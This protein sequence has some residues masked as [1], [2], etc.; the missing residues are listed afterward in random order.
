MGKLRSVTT[1]IGCLFFTLV[2]NLQLSAQEKTIVEIMAKEEMFL[3]DIVAKN[4]SSDGKKIFLLGMV[5]SGFFKLT[6][7]DLY[8]GKISQVNI[9]FKT[10][11]EDISLFCSTLDNQ[12]LIIGAPMF[13]L[14]PLGQFPLAYWGDTIYVYDLQKFTK[15]RVKVKSEL[16]NLS[17]LSEAV[18]L[19]NKKIL[20]RQHGTIILF[21]LLTGKEVWHFDI[22]H[23]YHDSHVDFMSFSPD[24]KYLITDNQL[25]DID[26]AEV[27]FVLPKKEYFVGFSPDNKYAIIMKK[28]EQGEG[29]QNEGNKTKATL[30]FL[31]VLTLKIDKHFDNIEST[32]GPIIHSCDKRNIFY[33]TKKSD[34]TW[35]KLDITTGDY[36]TFE[37][38]TK[39]SHERPSVISGN[40]RYVIFTAGFTTGRGLGSRFS[41]FD[42]TNGEVILTIIFYSFR[43]DGWVAFTNTGYY[44]SSSYSIED[45]FLKVAEGGKVYNITLYRD[46]LRKPTVIKSILADVYSHILN[47]P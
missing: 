33:K 8:S 3:S 36:M 34:N 7:I 42:I 12:Y 30:S 6:I 29:Q 10:M 25:W 44:D 21:D 20:L 35:A 45:K 37:I 17:D 23:D 27:K 1:T 4:V 13:Y 24:G 2:L 39:D 47:P 28:D 5:E 14:S 40:R 16:V 43:K 15:V 31:N 46:K 26:R 38:R 32:Y 19:N 9:D 11:V 41:I 22:K 18:C